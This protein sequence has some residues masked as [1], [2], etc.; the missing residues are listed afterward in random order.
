[1]N[2]WLIQQGIGTPQMGLVLGLFIGL[3]AAVIVGWRSSRRN[4]VLE[5]RISDREQHYQ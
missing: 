3:F 1:M 4:A 5:T 2:D